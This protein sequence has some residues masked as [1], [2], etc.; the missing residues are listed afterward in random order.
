VASSSRHDVVV[1][2]AVIAGLEAARRLSRQGLTVIVLEARPRVGGRIETHRLTGWPGPIEAGAEFVHGRPPAL[3]ARLRA[4]RAPLRAAAISLAGALGLQP[5][6]VLAQIEDAR[7]FDWASD[8]YAR[9]AYSWIPV[10]GVRAPAALAAPVENRL[11]F[12]GEAT[13]ADH[14]GTVHGALASGVRAAKEIS[15]RLR[16]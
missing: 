12:A 14:P 10:A 15:S 8:P 7:L 3:L 4:A 13:D 6:A 9:G 16:P 11:F 1:I 5:G 2:G